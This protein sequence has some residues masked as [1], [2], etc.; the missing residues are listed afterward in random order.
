MKSFGSANQAVV[1]DSSLPDSKAGGLI[2][3]LILLHISGAALLVATG[4]WPGLAWL[5]N[6]LA[7][8]AEGRWPRGPASLRPCP[9]CPDSPRVP[10]VPCLIP[11]SPCVFWS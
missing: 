2:A 6:G 4:W 3:S 10:P 11:R 8:L 1:P 7:G 9:E 5:L